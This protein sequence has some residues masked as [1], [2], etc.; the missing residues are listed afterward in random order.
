[1]NP[2]DTAHCWEPEKN[3]WN[4]PRKSYLLTLLPVVSDWLDSLI[5]PSGL[6][7]VVSPPTCNSSFSFIG[8][9]GKEFI[10]LDVRNTF[11]R[12]RTERP[13]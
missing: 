12:S 6:L 10:T 2:L 3:P 7:L 1:V 11:A 13:C 4:G 5:G 8:G 9:V